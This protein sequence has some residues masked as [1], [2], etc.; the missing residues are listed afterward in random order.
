MA[1][2]QYDDSRSCDDSSDY[3]TEPDERKKTC[4]KRNNS[5]MPGSQQKKPILVNRGSGMPQ[6]SPSSKFK[7]SPLKGRDSLSIGSHLPRSQSFTFHGC[8]DGAELKHPSAR[9][10]ERLTLVVDE[11]RFTVDAEIFRAHP[12]TMLGRMFG[13]SLE[14]NITRPNERGEYQVAEGISS[15]CFRAILEYYHHGIIHC[16]PTVAVTELREACD[17]L[18]IPFNAQT[19]KSQNLRALLHELSNE[20]ARKQFS[21]FLENYLIEHMVASAEH[22]DREFH[23]V[24]LTDEDIVD[25]DEEYPPT[26]MGEEQAQVIHNNQMYR[27]FK[28]VENRDVAKSVLKER[29][30]KKIRLGIEGYPTHKEKIKRRPGGR[31]EVIYNYVQR[32][33]VHMSWE[34]EEAKSRHVDFQC[35][36]SKSIT[37]LLQEVEGVPLDAEVA[38]PPGPPLA[39]LPPDEPYPIV[40]IPQEPGDN[41]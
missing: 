30:L 18:L 34:K 32:P 20:G 4:L 10:P 23:I 12:N 37:N 11:S 6:S 1:F 36:K 5:A 28:Y 2:R 15:M 7:V 33:F 38:P 27:F 31:P 8:G 16:P 26:Q 14:N 22:G 9:N 39:A 29:G 3:D 13:S 40:D 35:V 17:Y 21:E 25:W 24:I 19:I 41:E